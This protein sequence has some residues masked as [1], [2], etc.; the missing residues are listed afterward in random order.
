M[1]RAQKKSTLRIIRS[2]RT[3]SGVT[4]LM[5]A[6][7]PSAELLAKERAEVFWRK[8]EDNLSLEYTVGE[9]TTLRDETI[10]ACQI[11]WETETSVAA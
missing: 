9:S 3:V 11:R 4:A 5:L 8:F 2:Y 6:R 7:Y 10:S 1:I